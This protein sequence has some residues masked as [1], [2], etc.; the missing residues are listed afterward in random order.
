MFGETDGFPLGEETHDLER[1]SEPRRRSRCFG[2]AF[3][4]AS[5]D[6]SNLVVEGIAITYDVGRLDIAVIGQ[7][8]DH[9]V[10]GG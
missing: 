10:A 5:L 3:G 1:V 8:L 2:A 6:E 7:P 9:V 4:H